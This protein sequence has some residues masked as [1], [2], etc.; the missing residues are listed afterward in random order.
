MAKTAKRAAAAKP[1]SAPRGGGATR[2]ILLAAGLGLFWF[3]EY[4]DIG[5]AAD[6]P[7]WGYA[8]IVGVRLL[9]DF[10]GAWVIVSAVQFLLI[11]GRLLIAYVRGL[12]LQASSG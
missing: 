5:S 8:M 6:V 2:P 9:A 3:V 1:P 10:I 7:M 4:Q 11:V 12:W